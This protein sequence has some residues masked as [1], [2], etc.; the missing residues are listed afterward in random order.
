M[1]ENNDR[2]KA[3]EIALKFFEVCHPHALK[4]ADVNTAAKDLLD[5]AEKVVQ[6]IRQ[7]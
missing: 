4:P 5:T 2:L 7:S 6:F 3:L 1:N